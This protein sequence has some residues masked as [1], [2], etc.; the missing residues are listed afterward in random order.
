MDGAAQI[1]LPANLLALVALG[2]LTGQGARETSRLMLASFAAGLLA[3]ALLIALALRDPPAPIALLVLATIAGLIVACA[4]PIPVLIRHALSFA[5]GA[6][7]AL[8]APPQAVT[9]PAAAA[10]QFGTGIAALAA[11]GLVA[12]V[13]MKAQHGWQ[14]IGIRIVGSWIAA[15][16]ILVLALR[17][18]R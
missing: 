5:A 11:L 4:Q 8:D 1:L 7:L 12:L 14:R 16:A 9:I 6:A 18:V 15:S 2:L 3:G 10:A 17:F 13:A